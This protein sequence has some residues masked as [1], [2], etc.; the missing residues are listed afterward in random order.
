MS[1]SDCVMLWH[2]QNHI[3]LFT[4]EDPTKILG[5]N[6]G[7][8]RFMNQNGFRIDAIQPGFDRILSG[9]ARLCKHNRLVYPVLPEHGT[10]VCLIF[11]CADDDDFLKPLDIALSFQSVHDDR[12]AR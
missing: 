5:S 12:L 11:L 1:L 6:K 7:P 2:S 4:V 8:D 10:N 3:F 9:F